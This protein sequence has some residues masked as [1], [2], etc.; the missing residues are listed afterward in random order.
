MKQLS[1]AK[2]NLMTTF[3]PKTN[4]AEINM[5]TLAELT[6][7]FHCVKH[8]LSYSSTDCG[9]KLLP[10][11]LLDSAIAKKKT[12]GRTKVLGPKAEE[13]AVTALKTCGLDESR[14]VYFMCRYGY[15]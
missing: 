1:A 9:M 2:S 12:C 13:I 11:I 4:S 3:F 10:Q 5:I 6:Q 7:I 8:N 14:K 15:V